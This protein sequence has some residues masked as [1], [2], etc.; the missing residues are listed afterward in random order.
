MNREKSLVERAL[1]EAVDEGLLMLGESGREAVYFHLQNLY[2]V[3]KEEIPVK[4]E[5]FA[6]GLR[7]I[8]GLGAAVIEKAI[9]ESLYDK[10]GMKHEEKK[11]GKLYFAIEPKPNEGHPAMLLP[12]VASAIAFWRKLASEYGISLDKKGVNKEFGHS[13]MIGLDHLYDTVEEI[14]NSM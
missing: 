12:T 8:F 6:D 7:K 9:I 14:D 10:I 2:G 3:K 5:E 13:E 4:L 11:G 1:I